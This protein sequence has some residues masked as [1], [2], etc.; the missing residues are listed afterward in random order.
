M[1]TSQINLSIAFLVFQ[2]IGKKATEE[3]NIEFSVSF[4]IY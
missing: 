4:K 1:G 3:K 2:R